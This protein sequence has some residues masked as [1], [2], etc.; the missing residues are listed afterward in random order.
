MI[1]IS[2]IQAHQKLF[3]LKELFIIYN[4]NNHLFKLTKSYKRILESNLSH[5]I[6][7]KNVVLSN[8]IERIWKVKINS[9]FQMQ[10]NKM[11][12]PIFSKLVSMYS[13]P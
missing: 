9:K 3:F 13:I 8:L 6:G 2:L 1:I 4:N 5:N 12:E 7:S 10:G 11:E